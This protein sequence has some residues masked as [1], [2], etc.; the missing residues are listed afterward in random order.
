MT[1]LIKKNQETRLVIAGGGTGG[2]V[3]PGIAIA[4]ALGRLCALKVMWIGTGRPVE[5]KAIEN[6]PW[7]YRILD[8]KPLAVKNPVAV[9]KS[10]LH[11]P[12]N[13]FKAYSFLKAF[14]PHIVL[15][16]GGYVSGPVIIAGRLLGIPCAIHEQNLFPGLSN[17]WASKAASLIFVSLESTKSFFPNKKVVHAGNPVRESIFSHEKREMEHDDALHILV[18][19]GS[20]GAKGINRAVTSAL[21]LLAGQG[22]KVKVRHQTGPS[23]KDMVEER[24]R[25]SGL[26]AMVQPFIQDMGKAYAWSDIVICRA[27]AGTIAE[28]TALG[29]ASILIPYPFS[30]GGHQEAN[31]RDMKKAGAAVYFTED[32]MDP[33]TIAKKLK[34]LAEHPLKLKEMGEKAKALGK[35]QAAMEIAKL[36]LVFSRNRGKAPAKETINMKK[37]GV[38]CHV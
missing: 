24:Y 33:E 15:G 4:G 17:R 6:T 26:E 9:I 8:V 32:A 1:H 10:L 38:N 23:D 29:K 31:A 18:V 13:I 27:G 37:K 35:P 11:L 20:Q 21:I 28:L 14:R 16:V 3:F 7:D 19:G 36:L 2:H 12:L 25:T 34:D 30:A 22:L 5:R